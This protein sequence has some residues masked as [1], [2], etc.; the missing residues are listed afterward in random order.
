MSF[1]THDREII[2]YQRVKR[3]RVGEKAKERKKEGR[4]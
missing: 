1:Q 2:T 3:V 4:E